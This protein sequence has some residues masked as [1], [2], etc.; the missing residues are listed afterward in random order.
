MHFLEG[1][2]G[3]QVLQLNNHSDLESRPAWP[4]LNMHIV[5][6]FPLFLSKFRGGCGVY[7]W[8]A[9][10]FHQREKFIL[11]T[12]AVSQSVSSS[13]IWRVMSGECNLITSG[14][15]WAVAYCF[16]RHFSISRD[17]ETVRQQSHRRL[18][19]PQACSVIRPAE[20]PSRTPSNYHSKQAR[21]LGADL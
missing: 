7:R 2:A 19:E 20:T 12:S 8:S 1:L 13:L 6:L 9:G 3:V 11:S 15:P 10:P 17:I 4:S 18:Y 16:G 21:C 14:Q 5:H